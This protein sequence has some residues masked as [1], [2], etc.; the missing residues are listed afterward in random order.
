MI[1]DLRDYTLVP[2]A[3][4]KLVERFEGLFLDEQERLGARILGAFCDADDPDRFVWL[5][6]CAD[7][8]ARRRIL[9]A[10]YAEGEMWKQHRDEV[11]SWFIDTDNVLLLRASAEWAA[12]ASGESRVGMYSHLCD[13]PL[14]GDEIAGLGRDVADAI[15]AAG[16]R[17]LVTFATDPAENNYP[18]HPIRTGEHGLVWFA[19]F[20]AGAP[21]RLDLPATIVA[22]RR[23]VPTARSRM[24]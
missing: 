17:S 18:A 16:G 23:L 21:A 6:G 4:V 24:R 20:A 1:V 12:P 2:G 15:A 9:T 11:N 8:P 3:R 5:R 19:S 13:R 14:S 22:Q 10:F 7:L